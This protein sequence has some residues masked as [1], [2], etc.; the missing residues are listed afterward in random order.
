MND[1]ERNMKRQKRDPETIKG[2][3]KE[4]DEDEEESLYDKAKQ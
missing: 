3:A 4:E 1:N 2:K